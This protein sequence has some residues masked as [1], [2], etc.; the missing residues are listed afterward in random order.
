MSTLVQFVT[1]EIFFLANF[2]AITTLWNLFTGYHI[3]SCED[4]WH[5]NETLKYIRITET[6]LCNV[7]LKFQCK[8]I[9]ISNIEKYVWANFV[10]I[11]SELHISF[12]SKLKILLRLDRFVRLSE[13]VLGCFDNINLLFSGVEILRLKSLRPKSKKF[14]S[15]IIRWKYHECLEN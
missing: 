4:A 5:L 3:V 11:V 9:Q 7:T 15:I 8:T 1:F 14:T 10:W 13:N 2:C 6:D 12:L